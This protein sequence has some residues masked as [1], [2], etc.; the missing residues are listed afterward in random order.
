M[1]EIKKE[2]LDL[3]ERE[4]LKDEK[5]TI[6]RHALS[7]TK[8]TD[9]AKVSEERENTTNMF[10]IDIKTLPV[11]DQKRS[12]RCWIFAACN[13]IRE[14]VA[15]KYNLENFEV[16]QNYV[17]FYDKL[18]KC[19]YLLE[20]VIE[21]KDRDKFDRTLDLLLTTGIQ[22]GG[23]WDLFVNII[24]K[25][26]IV[27]KDAYPETFQSSNTAQIDNLLNKYIRK[28][29]FDIRKDSTD[30]EKRKDEY[31]K[32]IYK[33]LCSSFGVPPKTFSFEYVDKDGKYNIMKDLT[34]HSFYS[35]VVPIN[36]DDYVSIINSPTEDKPFNKVYTVDYIGN[37]I[38]GR[39]ILY[40]N[41]EMNRLKE[42]VISQLKDNETVWF[43]SDC[44]KDV[45]RDDCIW[46]DKA[47]D[48]DTLFSIDT[49]IS[50]EAMLDTREAAMNHA[51][52]ITGVSLDEEKP[53]KWKIEN[54]W[55]DMKPNKGYF[56]ATDSW[57]D[58]YVF[59]AVVNKKY[60]TEDE[61]NILVTDKI[62]LEPWDPMGMLAK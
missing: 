34:P 60:L 9:I 16:S 22:D 52:V 43:G 39:P 35:Y 4:Y 61:K 55:G 49:T 62:V 28:F 30:I 14:S 29:A 26:G 57:F 27:P 59:Q 7:K 41:L 45:D 48:I 50:K 10:S 47:L 3:I 1:R 31:M 21:L 2:E 37:V 8:I 17:S 5:A 32:N 6:A 44:T 51:M 18:E 11:T 20:K 15:K 53:T 46:D 12:G 54:S 13:I 25:Y 24:N 19:N 33:M 42:L 56:V 40:L 58:K 36:L 23:Q 38:E